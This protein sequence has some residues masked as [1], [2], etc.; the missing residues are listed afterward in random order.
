VCPTSVTLKRDE[1]KNTTEVE[2]ILLVGRYG[3]EG[4]GKKNPGGKRGGKKATAG[5][6]NRS[7][8]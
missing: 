4:C 3:E 1:R 6:Q 2:G 7:Y 5:Q 8:V